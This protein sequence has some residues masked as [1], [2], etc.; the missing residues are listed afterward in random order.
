MPWKGWLRMP[1][2]IDYLTETWNPISGCSGKGCKA[3]CFAR[4]MVRRFPNLHGHSACEGVYGGIEADPVPFNQVQF[5]PDRLDKPLHWRKPRRVGVCFMGD[6]FDEQVPLDWVDRVFAVMTLADQHS[7]FV[8]TKQPERMVE[9]FSYHK[10]FRNRADRVSEVCGDH[11]DY[12]YD[13]PDPA[14][15]WPLENVWLGVSVTDQEDADRMIPELLKVP[16]KKWV[17]IEPMLGPIF[18][19]WALDHPQRTALSQIDWVV[20]GCESGPKRRPCPHEW[21]IDVVEQCKYAGVPVWVKQVE[22]PAQISANRPPFYHPNQTRVSHD[23]DEW[24]EELRVR[25]LP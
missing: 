16:G 6:L 10:D 22:V 1:T 21:M 25:E 7:Y 15:K 12:P 11:F 19:D 20:L 17:S 9:Y 8:L 14:E 13:A 24:P 23:P 3:H 5:H 4:E 2:K 18:L